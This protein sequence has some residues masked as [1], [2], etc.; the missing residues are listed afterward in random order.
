M[1]STNRLKGDDEGA[2]RAFEPQ[3]KYAEQVGDRPQVALSLGDIG[4]VLILQERYADALDHFQRSYAISSSSGNQLNAAFDLTLR[5]DA[6]WRIGHYK[7]A[8]AD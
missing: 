6:L 4:T 1:G 7:E 5:G 8:E 3:L 2:L